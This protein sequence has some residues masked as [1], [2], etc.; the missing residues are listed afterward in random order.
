MHSGAQRNSSKKERKSCIRRFGRDQIWMHVV[1]SSKGVSLLA[2]C[3]V[4]V[5]EGYIGR[6]EESRSS[7]ADISVQTCNRPN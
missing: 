5:N 4:V 3:F 6:K 2:G 1:Q 7:T